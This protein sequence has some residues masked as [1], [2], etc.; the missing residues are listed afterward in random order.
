VAERRNRKIKIKQEEFWLS[1]VIIGRN[2]ALN[3]P[4]LFKSLP[5]GEDIEWIYVDSNST[6]NSIRIA[7]KYGAKVYRIEENSV[8]GPSTGRFVGTREAAGRWILYLD[9]D[10][11]LEKE[12]KEFIKRLKR[13]EEKMP[14][15]TAGFVGRTRNI[16]LDSLGKVVGESDYVVIPQREMGPV[17]K[18]GRVAAYHGG[19]V[20]YR[21]ELVLKARSWNPAVYQL[22]EIDLYSRIR[23]LKGV[24]RALDIPMVVHRTPQMSVGERLK[25]NFL[26]QYKG[27]KL[28]G[29][30]QVVAAHLETGTLAGFIRSYPHPFIILAGLVLTPIFSYFHPYLPLTINLAIAI[31]IGLRKKWYFYFVYLGNILQMVYGITRY[32][33]FELRYTRITL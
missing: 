12:F 32:K 4:A 22:E 13:E 29:A 10:M 17:E 1:I 33:P 15:S 28:Y 26:P 30:G 3:L 6:D 21:R 24:V 14:E 2:E 20:L 23:S 27:K 18:W 7:L 16:L 5:R 19:A 11:V 31:W 25:Q 8:Y 9:G